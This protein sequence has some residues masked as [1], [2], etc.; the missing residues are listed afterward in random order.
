[1]EDELK[2]KKKEKLQKKSEHQIEDLTR[3]TVAEIRKENGSLELELPEIER[4]IPKLD[5]IVRELYINSL[6]RTEISAPFGYYIKKNKLHIKKEESGKIKLI[7]SWFYK[8][9]KSLEEISVKVQLSITKIKNILINPVYFGKVISNGEIRKG[10]HP[11]IIDKKYCKKYNINAEKIM[12]RYLSL[13]LE[14]KN[15]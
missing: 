12:K 13:S 7:F 4:E 6:Q 14:S 1:M 5:E 3:E 2:T 8:Q 9:K 10:K 15:K 11:A